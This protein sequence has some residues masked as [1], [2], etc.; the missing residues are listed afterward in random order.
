M[1]MTFVMNYILRRYRWLVAGWRK[2]E[3]SVNGDTRNGEDDK[4]RVPVPDHGVDWDE[5][6]STNGHSW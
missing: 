5:E 2:S 6:D 1:D 3:D 4:D